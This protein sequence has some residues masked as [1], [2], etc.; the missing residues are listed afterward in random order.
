MREIPKAIFLVIDNLSSRF[1]TLILH[2]HVRQQLPPQLRVPL[3][4]PRIKLI[5]ASGRPSS[6]RSVRTRWPA[7]TGGSTRSATNSIENSTSCPP[8]VKTW[9][10]PAK[11]CLAKAKPSTTNST[12]SWTTSPE[13]SANK[14]PPLPLVPRPA[15]RPA[16]PLARQPSGRQHVRPP[17]KNQSVAPKCDDTG[18]EGKDRDARQGHY[19]NSRRGR[20]DSRQDRYGDPRQES[21][22]EYTPLAPPPLVQLEDRHIAPSGAELS[23]KL[24]IVKAQMPWACGPGVIDDSE[25]PSKKH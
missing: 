7:W 20:R 18:P 8:P 5:P 3:P 25:R 10:P 17:G 19:D 1:P 6:S 13:S 21:H 11:T 22:V 9:P 2:H 4:A 16:S 15:S 12:G 24:D 23:R 14:A